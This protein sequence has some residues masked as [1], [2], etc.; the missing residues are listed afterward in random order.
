MAKVRVF[1]VRRGAGAP[2]PPLGCRWCGHAPCTHEVHT[3][4]HRY[5]VAA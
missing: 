3:L 2:L 5:E 4:S 1:R